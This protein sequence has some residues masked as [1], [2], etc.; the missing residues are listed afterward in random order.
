M[1]AVARQ[2]LLANENPARTMVLRL[3]E[4]IEPGQVDAQLEVHDQR[5]W[6]ALLNLTNSGSADTGRLRLVGMIQHHNLFNRDHQG[7]FAYTTAP[8]RP[9]DVTQIGL[10]YRVPLYALGGVLAANYSYSSVNSGALGSGQQITGRGTTMGV[11]YTHYL[12]PAGIWRGNLVASLDDKLFRAATVGGVVLPTG[13]VRSR[14]LGLEAVVRADPDWGSF[15]ASLGLARN[16]GSGRD[17]DDTAYAANRAG[18]RAAWRALRYSASLAV[19]L[20]QGWAVSANLRGQQA[21]EPLIS[22]EQFG[23]GGATSVR[24]FGERAVTGDSGTSWSFEA[25]SPE[26]FDKLRA[27][28]FV[29][30]ARI[31]R[32]QP[33][34]GVTAGETIGSVGVGVRYPFDGGRGAL[35][36]DVARVVRGSVVPLVN[37]STSRAHLSLGLRF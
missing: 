20:P 17:N 35:A 9:G 37:R 12:H 34:P 16:L 28:A 5:P 24:G 21:S 32:E 15:G 30:G 10:A 7:T 14:P 25:W 13:D 3:A 6:N 1:R 23:V 4:S 2:V 8:E 26:L 31:S 29:D 18:A 27:L 36:L 11:N 22:G 19:R 33:V